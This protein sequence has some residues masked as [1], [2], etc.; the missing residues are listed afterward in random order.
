[1]KVLYI[2]NYIHHKN[3]H[4]LFNCKKFN[5]TTI[6]S[7]VFDK[8][9]NENII[10]CN[11]F[12]LIFSPSYL[13]NMS[14]YINITKPKF[15]F[16]PHISV[17][18][19]NELLKLYTSNNNVYFNVLSD[20]IINIWSQFDIC[21]NLKLVSLPFGVDTNI[22][23][24]ILPINKRQ[25]IMIYYKHRCQSDYDF[26]MNFC[27]SKNIPNELIKIFSYTNRYSETDF[28]NTL[29]N[30]KYCICIDAHESQGF[31]LQEIMSCNVP[32]FV[33]NVHSMTQETH[34]NYD[35]YP[36]TSIPYWD[37]ICGE[38]FKYEDEIE[39]KY[40]KF[41]NNLNNYNP[42]K[43]IIEYLSIEI[44]EQKWIDF[45]FKQ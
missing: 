43:F 26:I 11:E 42:R 4:F 28:I 32:L 3:N 39:I 14:N 1:M 21:N 31:A 6:S 36:T 13:L 22:F 7:N 2:K 25:Y 30:T 24:E 45:T 8:Y 41:I 40:T 20:W 9:C 17:F 44:C 34:T 15:L 29:H 12:D 18:P 38:Y 16:G 37:D 10:D 33:W 23:N 5:I 27:N 35:H 19:D